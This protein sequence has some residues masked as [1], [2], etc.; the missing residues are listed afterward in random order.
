MINVG[1]SSETVASEGQEDANGSVCDEVLV[2]VW[3][4]VDFVWVVGAIGW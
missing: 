1:R 2:C 4:V 3:I